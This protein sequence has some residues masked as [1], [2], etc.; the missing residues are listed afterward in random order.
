[1]TDLGLSI[2]VCGYVF[3]LGIHTCVSFP[4]PLCVGGVPVCMCK[5][6]RVH[7]CTYVLSWA[8]V[9]VCIDT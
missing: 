6:I 4:Y 1:M 8:C 2:I 9:C 3:C 5:C 7:A